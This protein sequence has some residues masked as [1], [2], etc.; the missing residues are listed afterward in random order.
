MG[1]TTDFHLQYQECPD[2]D[3]D[4]G[5]LKSFATGKVRANARITSYSLQ[6]MVCTE[7]NSSWYFNTQIW[8]VRCLFTIYRIAAALTR[9]PSPRQITGE[10]HGSLLVRFIKTFCQRLEGSPKVLTWQ[11]L[12]QHSI[13]PKH[14]TKKLWWHL[15]YCMCM[16]EKEKLCF[17]TPFY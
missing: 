16:K 12:G 6:H 9:I 10:P 4:T 1:K 3:T 17:L 15:E 7:T 5:T 13:R 2:T 8:L 14:T 11:M